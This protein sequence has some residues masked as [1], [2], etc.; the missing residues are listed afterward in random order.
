MRKVMLIDDD[1]VVVELLRTLLEMEGYDVITQ[2][3]GEEIVQ[4]VQNHKPDVVLMDVY[5]KTSPGEGEDGL[6]MLAQIREN[7]DLS[8]TRVIMSS[9]ID[10][11]V[12][13]KEYG[14]DGFLL[15]PYMP[16]ELIDLIKQV[17]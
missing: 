4:S 10:F 15:K 3:E 8:D 16:E 6:K 14:A 11:Q 2:C 7:P 9:G 5:L 17:S 1:V 13:S 12:E